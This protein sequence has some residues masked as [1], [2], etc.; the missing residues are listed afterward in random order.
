MKILIVDDESVQ[1]DLLR[2]FLENQGYEVLTA[3]DGEHA[4]KLFQQESVHLVLLDH[5]MPGL[6]GDQVLQEMKALNPL[7]RAIMITAYGAVDTAVG[8]MK[9]GADDFLEKPVDLKALLMKI[10]NIEQQLAVEEDITAIEDIVDEGPLPLKIIAKSQGMKEALSL[11][12]RVANSP[13]TVLIQ[14]ETG[15]GKELVAKLIHLLSP[16]RD[17]PFIEVNCAAV[18]ENLFESELFGHEKGAFTG[19]AARRRGCFELAQGG[20]LFL[21]E[22]GELPRTLQ[23]KLLRALQEKRISRVGSEGEIEIDVRVLVATNRNLRQMS[24]E[25]LFREDLYYRL[26]VFEIEIPPLR[27]RRE[28]IPALTEFFLKRY[29]GGPVS[30][31][32]DTTDVLMK[33][34]Y[35]GNVRELEHIVQRTVTLARGPLIRPSD[36]PQEVR[37]HQAANQGTLKERLEAVE[38]EMILSSLDKCDWVQTRAAEALGV[39][40]RV[41]RYKMVKHGITRPGD[42]RNRD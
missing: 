40:E 19:A 41:L 23:P 13:W 4:L 20:T 37:C 30:F 18:P 33:F 7:V 16:R 14:G 26:N 22:I 10:R 28:D 32:H 27:Q 3:G 12:G 2:G 24:K 38:N 15:T 34:Q 31:S 25:G 17:A 6:T 8:V 11:A 42:Q 29:A 5:R 9:L 39:S 21:D 35:P 1:I 36:L